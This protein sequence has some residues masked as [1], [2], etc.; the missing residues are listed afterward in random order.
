M[1]VYCRK[2]KWY[3]DFYVNG[4]RVRECVGSS[5]GEASRALA[6][7]K[8]EAI[9]GKFSFH[10][11]KRSSLFAE[12]A[13]EYLAYCRANKKCPS[14]DATSLKVLIPFFQGKRL[15]DISAFDVEKFKLFRKKQVTGASTNR[16]LTC[17][18]S[19]FNKA[20]KWHKAEGNP[21][22]EIKF[23]REDNIIEKILTPD[24]LERLLA[25]CNPHIKPI[26]LTAVHSGMR[27]NE[28]LSLEWQCVD[29]QKKTITVIQSKSGR[30][31]KIPMNMTLTNL[32]SSLKGNSNKFVFGSGDNPI[33]SV[34]TAFESAIKRSGVPKVRFHDLRHLFATRL[35]AAGVDLVTVQQLLG[36]ST[37]QMTMRYAHS[38]ADSQRRAVECLEDGVFEKSSHNL[39]TRQKKADNV[40]ALSACNT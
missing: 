33:K 16:D 34:R 26:I 30:S 38:S 10:K 20:V 6:V 17:L 27:L 19:L 22:V 13:E 2:G 11:A 5:K 40:V 21:V 14:R 31:R 25:E 39:V 28:I 15:C 1:S 36:H 32:F 37:I 3:I 18:K 24:E 8:S 29:M 35:V 7:R 4:C 23:F 12:F 9:Q